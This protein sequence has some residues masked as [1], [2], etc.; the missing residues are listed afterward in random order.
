M[1][2]IYVATSLY[3]LRSLRISWESA[4]TCGL[5]RERSRHIEEMP[6]AQVKT[7]TS[8]RSVYDCL[9]QCSPTSSPSRLASSV[10]GVELWCWKHISRNPLGRC[11]LTSVSLV[12]WRV[13]ETVDPATRFVSR[14]WR[15]SDDKLQNCLPRSIT[16][17]QEYHYG[18][19]LRFR[20]G[21]SRS[22]T[23]FD[24]RLLGFCV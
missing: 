17:F 24:H 22:I 19:F 8:L 18:N 2:Y 12:S 16:L 15:H 4:K 21:V 11:F 9:N 5:N 10:P 7:K 13:L 3:K 23:F 20:C 6:N 14:V 1:S